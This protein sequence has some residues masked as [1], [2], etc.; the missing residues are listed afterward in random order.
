MIGNGHA[1]LLLP[2]RAS[3][4]PRNTPT[5]SWTYLEWVINGSNDRHSLVNANHVSMIAVEG[6]D[7]DQG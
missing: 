1:Y 3:E 2:R 5:A 6:T 7:E 4:G